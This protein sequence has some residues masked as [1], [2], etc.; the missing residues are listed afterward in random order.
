MRPDIKTND[1]E[2]PFKVFVGSYNRF[3]N[4]IPQDYKEISEKINIILIS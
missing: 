3:G 4:R 1:I 2:V